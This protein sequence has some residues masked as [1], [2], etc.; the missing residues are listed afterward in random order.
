MAGNIPP[1]QAEA[2]T[3]PTHFAPPTA[4]ELRSQGVYRLQ[5]G[6]FGL[7]AILLIVGLANVIRDRMVED[8]SDSIRSVVAVD[9]KP[10]KIASDPLADIGVVPAADPSP[11]PG[12]TDQPVFTGK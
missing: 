12:A 3:A 1:F 2:L 8:T 5:I 9:S 10:T 7:C 4:R 11:S 6:L